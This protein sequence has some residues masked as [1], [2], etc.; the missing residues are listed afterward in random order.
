VKR[1]AIAVAVVL[2]LALAY[3]AAHLALIEVGREVI[4]L[5][6][7]NDDGTWRVTRLWIVDHDGA[8]WLHGAD[9]EWMH[10]LRAR[11]L[12]EV[13]RA[14]ETHR[15]RAMPVP[16]PHPEIHERLREKYGIADWWVRLMGPDRPSTMPVRL[17]RVEAL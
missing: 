12:V 5:R 3:V 6:T 9:S 10:N 17:E 16:G 14:G 1:I 15:Y 2:G 13:E 7:E 4:V 8:A 11:P